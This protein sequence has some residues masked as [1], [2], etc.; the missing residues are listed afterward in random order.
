MV[1]CSQVAF[2]HGFPLKNHQIYS[3]LYFTVT[4]SAREIDSLGNHPC[5]TKRI[6]IG[7]LRKD[8]LSVGIVNIINIPW[9]NVSSDFANAVTDDGKYST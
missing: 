8:F 5:V 6:D 2:D 4:F 1:E 3:N 9:G 7:S